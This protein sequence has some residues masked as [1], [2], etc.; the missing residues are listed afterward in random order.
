[1]LH[2]ISLSGVFGD[3]IHLAM[4]GC[5]LAA[6]F[7][8]V[9]STADRSNRPGLRHCREIDPARN[10]LEIRTPNG[11]SVSGN[12]RRMAVTTITGQARDI[13]AAPASHGKTLYHLQAL[14]GLAASLVVLSH[15]ADT[16]AQRG[17]MAE[18]VAGRLGISGYFGVATFFMISGFIIF[19]TS[20]Q[21]FGTLRGA[22]IFVLKR[23]IR[24][25]PV[26][27]IATALFV[28]LSPHRADYGAGDILCSLLLVP[29]VITAAGN[30][31][32][33]VGQGWTLQYEI[34][35]YLIFAAGLF[36][37]RT[38]G[39][40]LIV[41][42]LAALVTAGAFIMPLGD[43]AE[44]LTIAAYWTR[45][46]ILLFAA[47]IGFGLLQE[48]VNRSFAV[49]YPFLAMLAVLGL[50]FAYSLG[51]PLSASEQIQFPTVL[52]IWLLCGLWVFASI[53][54]RSGEGMFEKAAEAFGDASYSVYLF[55]TF[56]LSALLRL[57]LQDVSP[58][59]FV[60]AAL[61]GANIFGFVM[62]RLVERPILRTFRGMLAQA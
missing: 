34:L 18:G 20:R 43:M 55:H 32:P 10:R 48:R 47:G 30:M 45:P 14:R 19:K 9:L 11:I 5:A 27:W 1:M 28:M 42:A 36:F 62:Y 56:V 51:A 8:R 16:L 29:H 35:F 24:I 50:W 21:S 57:K 44:P 4:T 6:W 7:Y 23:L 15:C 52:A 22:G 38:I 2:R 46:I 39:T 26:Y 40:G 13:A 17:L 49:P 53:F 33:L 3:V 37:T 41:A 61:A 58:V 54:G 59:L 12:P 31:H 60:V 25:F